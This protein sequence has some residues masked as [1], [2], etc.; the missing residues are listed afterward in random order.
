[1]PDIIVHNRMGRSVYKRL[2][3]ELRE[4]IDREIYRV[5]LLGPDPYAAYRFFAMPL[6][7]GVHKRMTVMHETKV[8][9][10]LVEMA[11]F[12]R[13][14]EMFS[15]L[16]GFLC[17]YALDSTA[18]PYIDEISGY[19]GYMHMAVEHRLDR[20]E[21]DRMGRKLADRA[22]TRG[23]YTPFLPESMHRDYETVMENV[24]GWKDSWK[25]FKESYRHHK[26]YYFLAEDPHGVAELLF[27]KVPVSVMNGKVT[28]LSYRSHACDGMELGP[29]EVLRRKAVRRAVQLIRAV[30]AYRNGRISEARLR[31]VI[32]NKDYSGR[33]QAE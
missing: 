14:P 19:K 21:L 2:P 20:M 7:H 17:H 6:R 31:A 4:E 1:M 22:I 12:S 26:M 15:Y 32:G 30:D 29:F 24:F 8:A 9:D 18:H 10:F 28:I 13:K 16:A 25:R 33:E 23:F 3:R 11:K 27:H 5:G